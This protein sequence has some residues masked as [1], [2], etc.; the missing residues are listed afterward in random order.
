MQAA[1][2]A[3]QE[4]HHHHRTDEKREFSQ[5]TFLLL[6]VL[7]RSFRARLRL[8]QSFFSFFSGLRAR[9]R[10]HARDLHRRPR[11]LRRPGALRAPLPRR[12][13][14]HGR[15]GSQD[16]QQGEEEV[17]LGGRRRQGQVVNREREKGGEERKKKNY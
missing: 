17:R 9:V 10:V 1:P 6:A 13:L 12:R 7:P 15:A 16:A 11:G 14:H 5:G 4:L 3:I 8:D 2:V